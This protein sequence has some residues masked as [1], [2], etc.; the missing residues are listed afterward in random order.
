MRVDG[1]MWLAWFLVCVISFAVLETISMTNGIPGDTL[2]ATIR[3]NVPQVALLSALT[4][5]FLWFV[6]HMLNAYKK[7]DDQ[8]KGGDE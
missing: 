8:L 1:W 3:R 2:T 4:G 6:H 7:K 5:F